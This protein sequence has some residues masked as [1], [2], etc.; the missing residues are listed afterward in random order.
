MTQKRSKVRPSLKS[1]SADHLKSKVQGHP[2]LE[3]LPEMCVPYSVRK[4]HG[5]KITYFNFELAKEL[6]L[7]PKSHNERI[8]K[9]LESAFLEQFNL[10]IINEHDRIHHPA[11]ESSDVKPFNCFATRY[12]QLQHEDKTGRTSGDGRAIWNGYIQNRNKIWDLSSRGT[13]VTGLAPGLVE[14]GVPLPTGSEE[15]GYSCGLSEIEEIYTSALMSER[16][17]K[18]GISTERILMAIDNGNG[19]GIAIRAHQNLIRPAHLFRYLK[20]EDHHGAKTLLDYSIDRDFKNGVI[21]FHS[22]SKNAYEKYLQVF[23]NNFLN[24]CV[25]MHHKEILLWLDWDGD[26]I[27][28]DG[29][30]ID[31]GSVRRFGAHHN[32]YKYDDVQRFSPNLD[33]QLKKAKHIIQT[34]AQLSHYISTA[35]KKPIREF[36]NLKELREFDIEFKNRLQRKFLEDLGLSDIEVRKAVRWHHNLVNELHEEFIKLKRIKCTKEQATSD[37]LNQWPS[38]NMNAFLSNL[39][40]QKKNKEFSIE[41]YLTNFVEYH[42][43]HSD[44]EN[45]EARL[46]KFTELLSNFEE[47]NGIQLAYRGDFNERLTTGAIMDLVA[48]ISS[49]PHAQI[50]SALRE[51]IEFG[52]E[53]QKTW[54]NEVKKLY[55]D[56]L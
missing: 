26:N 33:E 18:M 2:L 3:V 11:F 15:F 22:K 39:K 7:L 52:F 16:F 54:I 47:Q 34:F 45:L 55:R 36:K 35:K 9:D 12:L 24:L 1:K 49:K 42:P 40:N 5:G 23:A 10:R 20:L 19:L 14:A 29:G 56:D 51:C 43:S 25:L 27:L 17:Y 53:N 44:K 13:G 8:S 38:L 4:I 50:Q 37:G 28:M 30:I 32:K 41:A 21:N 31:Y 48:Q 6:G 46:K